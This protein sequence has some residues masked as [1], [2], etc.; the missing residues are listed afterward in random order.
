MSDK[1]EVIVS[2]RRFF[3]VSA[4]IGAALTGLVGLS[5]TNSAAS[6]RHQP[7]K[8][9]PDDNLK[10]LV[11]VRDLNGNTLGTFPLGAI[12]DFDVAPGPGKEKYSIRV[13][14]VST[15]YWQIYV[16]RGSMASSNAI[17]EMK[18]SADG[19]A[20][21]RPLNLNLLFQDLSLGSK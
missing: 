11:K 3:G 8:Q 15:G 6:A 10:G 4:A 7:A 2:R 17:S 12:T 18:I 21:F 13:E 1:E 5:P 9:D 20:I 14:R 19:T 16:F